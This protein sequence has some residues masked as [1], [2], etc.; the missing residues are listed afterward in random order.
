[1]SE[2]RYY[3]Y[4]QAYIEANR[5]VVDRYRH[6]ITVDNVHMSPPDVGKPVFAKPVSSANV[7]VASPALGTPVLA[8]A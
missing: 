6:C 5:T 1:M 3:P 7:V 4:L 2:P 8:A